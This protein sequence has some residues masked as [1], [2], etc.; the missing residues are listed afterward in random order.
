MLTPDKIAALNKAT[1][2]NVN[3]TAPAGAPPSRAQEIMNIGSSQSSQPGFLSNLASGLS[4]T[5]KSIGQDFKDSF[6]QGPADLSLGGAVKSTLKAGQGGLRIAG[7]IAGGVNKVAGDVVSAV[8][9]GIPKAIQAIAN[10]PQGQGVVQ[11]YQDYVKANP[12]QAKNLEAVFNL[13]SAVATVGGGIEGF[14]K[15]ADVA[16]Q[17]GKD[18]AQTGSDIKSSVGDTVN[19][20]KE[21]VGLKIQGKPLSDVL[22]TPES[23]VSK[24]N[25]AERK[26]WFD[27]QSEQIA[28]QHTDL[29]NQV[30]AK[31]EAVNQGINQDLQTK[32]EASTAQAKDL[33]KQ[34]A[35][36]TRDETLTLRPKMLQGMRDAS[37]TYRGLVAEDLAPH[38]NVPVQTT[39]LNTYIE[40][41]FAD[42]P[43][44]AQAI[45]QKLGT[46]EKV[47]PL[48]DPEATVSKV[49]PQTTLGEL[50]QKTLDLKQTIG[51]A[52]RKGTAVFTSADKLTDDAIS[53]LSSYM[54]EQGVDLSNANKFWSEYAPVRNQMVSEAQ[55]FN[56]AGTKTGTFAKTLMRVAKGADVNNENFISQVEKIVGQP[57]GQ[58]AKAIVAKL[59]ENE[60]TAL[61]DKVAADAQKVENDMKAT[62]AKSTVKELKGKA[63]SDLNAKQFEVE[64]QAR[65]NT[66]FRK[67]GYWTAGLVADKILKST[68][69]IGI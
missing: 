16:P 23:E 69:G 17:I 35:T 18:L 8:A 24:L 15:L 3:P 7:D 33:T 1:G 19:K 38:A 20:A 61:A 58:D 2:N 42:N 51:G 54:K 64:R 14:N 37:T 62:D 50:Y 26:A 56:T 59:G 5:A 28:K 31:H 52:A 46:I 55:P 36:S 53:T 49:K 65:L 13:G 32:A 29:Q 11:R 44:V 39:D 22:A 68:T 43:E 4:D 48:S 27:N 25:P 21:S 12:E 6:S 34:L 10:T 63:I 45:K 41:R 66:F 60:K 57:I 67:A 40:N 30:T 47:N 9:P